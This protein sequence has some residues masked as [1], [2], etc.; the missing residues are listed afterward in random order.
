MLHSGAILHL[1]QVYCFFSSVF[2][3]DRKHAK[4]KQSFLYVI[5]PTA[6]GSSRIITSPAAIFLAATRYLA[7]KSYKYS[8][9]C[10]LRSDRYVQLTP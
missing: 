8:M 5:G 1:E 2:D 3:I 10:Q 9:S 7:N 4:H 6:I